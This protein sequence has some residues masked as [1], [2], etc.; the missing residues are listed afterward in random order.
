MHAVELPAICWAIAVRVSQGVLD[1]APTVLAG[2]V[3]TG[4]LR[5]LVGREWTRLLFG[6]HGWQGFVR[7]WVMGM[8]L[9]V[10]SLGA[11]PVARELRRA[12]LSGGQV[13]AFL[14]A[15]PLFNPLTMLYGLTLARPLAIWVYGAC[16]LLLVLAVGWTWDRLY[17]TRGQVAEHTPSV[18]PGWQR[19]AAV[20]AVVL[21]E[22][23][24]TIVLSALGLVGVAVLA[25][26]LP[27]GAL[28]RSMQHH[29]WWSP[30]AMWVVAVPAYL[31]PM[32]AMVQLGSMFQ[33]GNSPGAALVLLILG[34]GVNPATV[35][36][37]GR[38]DGWRRALMWLIAATTGVL[39]LAYILEHPLY[40][41]DVEV[42]DHTHAFDGY[43]RPVFDRSVPLGRQAWQAILRSAE[44]H[45]LVGTGIWLIVIVGGGALRMIDPTHR[46]ERYLERSAVAPVRPTIWNRP[47]SPRVLGATVLA[48][49][50]VASV[51]ACYLY[52]PPL[53]VVLDEMQMVQA[54]A[55]SLASSGRSKEALRQLEIWDDLTRKL[56]VSMFLREGRLDEF[57]RLKIE[58][59]R[60]KLELLEHAVADKQRGQRL[61]R[62]AREVRLAFRRLRMALAVRHAQG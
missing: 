1:A 51:G 19:M 61:E 54:D 22:G 40:P 14:L 29:Q 50:V 18:E 17:P 47:L 31:A 41:A 58:I 21:R 55:L 49:L 35:W 24:S 7:A 42:A 5:R 15:A 36:W 10:C 52:Y 38:A 43:T 56:Q 60:D 20:G 57:E 44:P 32:N 53:A 34:T 6:G 39:C 12:G 62:R 37:V 3:I 11:L 4:I 48:A 30:L 26:V 23:P 45:E 13:L 16:S 8:L 27:H 2:L 46:L 33:H 59:L 28:Q 9:P 25:A